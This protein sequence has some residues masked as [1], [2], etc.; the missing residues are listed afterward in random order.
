[1]KSLEQRLHSLTDLE[2]VRFALKYRKTMPNEHAEVLEAV[3]KDR[4]SPDRWTRLC[5]E[6]SRDGVFQA[7]LKQPSKAPMGQSK[8]SKHQQWWLYVLIGTAVLA[9]AAYMLQPYIF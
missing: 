1:M 2:L 3:I 4:I 7:K 5:E 9:L 6:L 8:G